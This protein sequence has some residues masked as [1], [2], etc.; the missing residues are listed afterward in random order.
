[1]KI[2]EMFVEDISRRIEVV[3][4]VSDESDL[5]NEVREFVVT[6][7]VNRILVDLF[8][9]YT[10]DASTNPG[11]WLS[12]FFGTGKSH[13]LKMISHILSNREV[14]GVKLGEYFKGKV[15]DDFECEGLV[16]NV[17]RIP[18]QTILFNI[19]SIAEQSH[20][21][22]EANIYMPFKRMF[23]RALGFAEDPSVAKL[24]RDLIYAGKFDHF[25][26]IF[27]R[28]SGK[29]W[30]ESRGKLMVMGKA[31]D[32]A[33]AEALGYDPE[34]AKDIKTRYKNDTPLSV[35][36]F[37]KDI[38]D[39]L[40]TKPS[41][42]RLVFLVDEIGQFISRDQRTMLNLQ[43]LVEDLA[44][45]FKGRVWVM[46]TAQEEVTEMVKAMTAAQK[47]DF[48]KIMAR[49]EVRVNLTSQNAREV[50]QKR[51]L[52]KKEDAERMLDDYYEKLGQVIRTRF[53]FPDD[54]SYNKSLPNGDNFTSFYPILPYQVEL[55]QNCLIS[56][57]N[58]GAFTGNYAAV[59][60]RSMLGVFQSAL[61]TV[62]E[63]SLGNF[64]PFDLFFEGT[65]AL[66]KA[67]P[68][69]TISVLESKN[70]DPFSVRILK[71]LYLLKY[72]NSF[73]TT[74]KNLAVLMSENSDQDRSALEARIQ[75]AL[76]QLVRYSFVQEVSGVYEYQT[77]IQQEVTREINN[78]KLE[79]GQLRRFIADL[80]YREKAGVGEI[81]KLKHDRTG[82][83]FPYS[84]KI[85]GHDHGTPNGEISLHLIIG[86]EDNY[87]TETELFT[88]SMAQ[89]QLMI[90]VPR[91]NKLIEDAALYLK[92]LRYGQL[93]SS[94]QLSA[95]KQAVITTK[96]GENE[97]RQ[98]GIIALLAALLGEARFLHNG[99]ELTSQSN[100]F[101]VKL[102]EAGQQL[103]DGSYIYL[104]KITMVPKR[105]DIVKLLRDH[106]S[107]GLIAEFGGFND[108][109]NELLAFIANKAGDG[110]RIDLRSM[111]EYFKKIPYG[112]VDDLI[113]PHALVNLFIHNKV[114]IYYN[115]SELNATEIFKRLDNSKDYSSVLVKT[116]EDISPELLQEARRFHFDWFGRQLQATDAKLMEQ[117]MKDA[118]GKE[119][120]QLKNL[121]FRR[122][123]YP[124]LHRIEHPLSA[125]EKAIAL[126]K[127]RFFEY[128]TGIATPIMESKDELDRIL[129]F[130]N[131]PNRELFD[132]VKELLRLH[133]ADLELIE[134]P[135]KGILEEYM[136][137]PE[138]YRDTAYNRI[139]NALID[140]SREL[141]ERTAAVRQDLHHLLDGLHYGIPAMEGFDTVPEER[142]HELDDVIESFR[143]RV[144][145][146]PGLAALQN[147]APWLRGD[148][149]TKLLEKLHKLQPV[150][151]VVE[152]GSGERKP[153]PPAKK[154]QF[155]QMR[156][157]RSDYRKNQITTPE[158][159]EEYLASL[160]AKMLRE[161]ENG[162]SI[163]PG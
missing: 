130:M 85:D 20:R 138:P 157:I 77:D 121:L 94:S 5:L 15:K 45:A 122:E 88:F 103:I 65:R 35:E 108:V 129:L 59:G 123:K 117:E 147:I 18:T 75:S 133:A 54:T 105:E 78:V 3:V 131:G 72:E 118:L 38:R 162:N 154:A 137:A 163:I 34:T 161:L 143:G 84:R 86:A 125:L 116:N 17:L 50:I 110:G 29:E 81:L 27:K 107:E 43:T 39:Y 149:N 69:H 142:R 58:H 92:T 62:K 109:E 25:K 28:I 46:V 160:R 19:D 60:A 90:A 55:F 66:L 120:Q 11:V 10:S 91:S 26:E 83:N 33:F 145:N 136:E 104:K 9:R 21:S 31:L 99:R 150:E 52:K 158:E 8:G 4:K 30:L 82:L 13:L 96:K 151:P 7:E 152:T 73:P 139:N 64:V 102:R 114:T 93:N 106:T 156:N 132:K 119:A 42:F 100:D 61:I 12:G 101:H 76:D 98:R 80:F 97:Q 134:S 2:H 44:V 79:D 135:A 47:S 6:K 16:T 56:L 153:E 159:V 53:N 115:V 141:A 144:E 24:E 48:S 89:H 87:P 148:V 23:D 113:I 155:V 1:M 146:S 71:L 111:I 14:D 41:N 22:G 63:A 70:E 49:F 124:F 127:K 40:E 36:S 112:Y 126:E 32:A 67:Q 37:I 74:V 68:F 140:L 57:S 51:L 128:I 95:E